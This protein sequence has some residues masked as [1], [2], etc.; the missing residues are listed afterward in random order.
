MTDLLVY[1][2]YGYTGRLISAA[3]AERGMDLTIAGRTEQ[4]V[5]D[6]AAELGCE[7]R[8]FDL[9]DRGAVEE[10]AAAADVL[11]NCAGPFIDT[12]EPLVEACLAGETHYL[13]ITGEIDVFEGVADYDARAADA[14]VT[15]MPGVGFD[16]VPTDCLAAHLAERL[17]EATTLTLAFEGLDALSPGT[18]KT[19]VDNAEGGLVRREGRLEAVP[20]AYKTRRIDFGRGERT[21]VTIPWGDVSTAYRT[22]GIPNVEVYMAAP[23]PMVW[24]MR[25]GRWFEPVLA[26]EPVKDALK[27][28]I[29][30]TVDGPS[31]RARAD[32]RSHVWGE[33]TTDHGDRAVSRLETPD[34]Y[35]LTVDAA[36]EIADRVGDGQAPAG[37]QTPAGAFGPDLVLD[38]PDTDRE[39]V[40]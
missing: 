36:L 7:W 38:L 32:A 33:V 20:A 28:L 3:A 27:R 10:N 18:A 23:E 35:S 40:V 37:Y 17:P 5:R 4:T 12:Y 22:T 16:V 1:G 31:E 39:D 14:G 25:A 30:A 8:A 29:D 11:L 19:M 6:Q 13:D 24:A 26:A 2:S 21:A 34:G 9:A 15:C